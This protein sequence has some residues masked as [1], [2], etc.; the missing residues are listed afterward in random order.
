MGVGITGFPLKKPPDSYT[1]TEE[2]WRSLSQSQRRRIRKGPAIREKERAYRNRPDIKADIKE[3]R[4]R[5]EVKAA[6]Y[7]TY[8]RGKDRKR[9]IRVAQK[10]MHETA[11]DA[12]VVCDSLSLVSDSP[13]GV[14]GADGVDGGDV[15]PVGEVVTVATVATVIPETVEVVQ[16]TLVFGEVYM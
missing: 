10:T 5:P 4:L 2:H 15:A 11:V 13:D 7:A 3:Y 16:A 14:D 1:G 8:V 12:I 9:A 6:A